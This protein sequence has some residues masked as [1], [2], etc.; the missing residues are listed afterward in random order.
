MQLAGIG[1]TIF[2]RGLILGTL[3]GMVREHQL[4]GILGASLST[5]HQVLQH[6]KDL[7]LGKS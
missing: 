5:L 7:L 3:L 6:L 4:S 2:V 1:F